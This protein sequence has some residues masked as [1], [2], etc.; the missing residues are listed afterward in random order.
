MTA[1]RMFTTVD[2]L[3]ARIPDGATVAVPPD[4]SGTAMALTRALI[5][6]GARDL[7]LVAVPASGLQADM[8]VGAGCIGT[9]EV[10][11]VTMGEFGLAPRFSAAVKAGTVKLKD[12]TCPALHAAIQAAEKGV[13]FTP[14]RGILGADLIQHRDDWKVIDNPFNDSDEADPIVL[15]P[16]IKPDVAIFH[17]TLADRDGNVWIG[18]RRELMTMA[19]AS[20]QTLVTVEAI[21]DDNLLA[22]DKTAAGTIPA[23]YVTAVA[24]A[25]Q[26]AWPVGFLDEYPVDEAHMAEYMQMARTE[27]GFAEYVARYVRAEPAAAAAE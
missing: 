9:L 4:Y 24:E 25:K 3:A 16:A 6:R 27:E 1:N 26:G 22:T 15:L 8:L 17:A 10:A 2:E 19:H 20:R 14:L 5:R 11:A 7:H 13:P 23:L 12:A 21:T 18:Q